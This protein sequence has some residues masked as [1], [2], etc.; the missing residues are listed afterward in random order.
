MCGSARASRIAETAAA[1]T[2]RPA[3]RAEL[4]HSQAAHTNGATVN[5]SSHGWLKLIPSRSL[6]HSHG[7]TGGSCAAPAVPAEQD[8]F[9][10]KTRAT[11]QSEPLPQVGGL[12]DGRRKAR[13]TVAR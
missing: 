8:P 5:G 7:R 12:G 13:H 2:T 3:R 4:R 10:R 9:E 1:F 11:G 6:L